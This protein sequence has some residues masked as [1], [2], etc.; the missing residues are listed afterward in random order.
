MTEVSQDSETHCGAV[1]F[2]GPWYRVGALLWSGAI[3]AALLGS[4]LAVLVGDQL[5]TEHGGRF[6]ALLAA[7]GV[8]GY[9]LGCWI[10][11]GRTPGLWLCSARLV[12]FR[13]GARPRPWQCLVR[14]LIM[15]LSMAA[16]TVGVLWVLRQPHRRAWHDLVA[17]TAVIGDGSLRAP[18]AEERKEAGYCIQSPPWPSGSSSTR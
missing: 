8:A 14:F 3:V 6:G 5:E 7:L 16:L 17:R 2:I 12:D 1:E 13:S 15:P 18:S 4:A 10:L 9:T 11:F